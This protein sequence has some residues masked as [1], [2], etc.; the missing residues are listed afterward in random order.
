MGGLVAAHIAG[1][2]PLG[3][4]PWLVPTIVIAGGNALIW[5]VSERFYGTYSD[6][7]DS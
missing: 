2:L 4:Q 6:S 1:M 5:W 7:Q 3:S